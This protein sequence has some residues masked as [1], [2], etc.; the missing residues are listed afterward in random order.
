MEA[1]PRVLV[2]R[3]EAVKAVTR[4]LYRRP[5]GEGVARLA[6]AVRRD[7]AVPPLLQRGGRSRLR[8]MRWWLHGGG[9]LQAPR[10]A[11][12]LVRHRRGGRET[13]TITS[14]RDADQRWRRRSLLH[15]HQAPLTSTLY[16]GAVEPWGSQH[17]GWDGTL[18]HSMTRR[19]PFNHL[20]ARHSAAMQNGY[21]AVQ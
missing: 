11:V 18:Q 3:E 8:P 12:H 5:E 20:R 4:P 10:Q 16:A 6:T 17:Q 7:R 2:G 15:P 9:R 13:G 21:E 19:S 14:G 1:G